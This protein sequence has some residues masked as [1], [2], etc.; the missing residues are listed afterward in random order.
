MARSHKALF[1]FCGV[2]TCIDVN[3]PKCEGPI[4]I[5]KSNGIS[6]KSASIHIGVFQHS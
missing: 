3:C 1:I 5:R 4:A 2:L 6:Q